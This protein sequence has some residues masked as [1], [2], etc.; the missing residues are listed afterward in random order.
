M[1]DSFK[2]QLSYAARVPPDPGIFAARDDLMR[3]G[4]RLPMSCG[5]AARVEQDGILRGY[6]RCSCAKVQVGRLTI[7]PQ[8][9]KLP[10]IAASRKPRQAG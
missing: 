7:G 10:R 5:Y 2:I 4:H 3:A 6:R 9:D 8:L 1:R